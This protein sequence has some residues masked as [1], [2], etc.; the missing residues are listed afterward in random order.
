M[1][2]RATGAFHGRALQITACAPQAKI[3]FCISTRAPANICS[4]TSHHKRSCMKQQ[5]KLSKRASSGLRVPKLLF[6]IK[7]PFGL[8]NVPPPPEIFVPHPKFL[9]PCPPLKHTTLVL[10]LKK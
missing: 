1:S 4:K 10:V 7:R 6:L 9:P 8:Q 3:K 2:L 5:D